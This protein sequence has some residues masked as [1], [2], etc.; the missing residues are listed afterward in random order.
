M[1]HIMYFEFN[2]NTIYFSQPKKEKKSDIY[3]YIY[4]YVYENNLMKRLKLHN[5][6]NLFKNIP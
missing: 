1:E 2:K 6:N 5:C 3:I 4:I